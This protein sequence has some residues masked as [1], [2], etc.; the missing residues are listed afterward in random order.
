MSQLE[1]KTKTLGEYSFTCHY[2]SPMVAMPMLVELVKMFGPGVLSLLMAQGEEEKA[3]VPAMSVME[4][5]EKLDSV[6]LQ[7]M[8]DQLCMGSLVD[9]KKLKSQYELVFMGRMGLL[10][11]WFGW[12]LRV[13][14]G[15]FLDL[16]GLD[17]PDLP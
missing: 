6:V 5:F 8:I 17:L 4:F 15:D 1:S 10:V 13:Q 16:V 9:G 2:I 11:Q 14:F 7:K 3:P 12:T